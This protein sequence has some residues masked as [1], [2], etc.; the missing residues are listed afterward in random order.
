MLFQ[1]KLRQAVR[2]LTGW[3]KGRLLSPDNR[4]TKTGELVSEVLRWKHPEPVELQAEALTPFTSV[5]AF[6]DVN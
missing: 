3:E 2:W 1:G 5:P 4:C 6:M